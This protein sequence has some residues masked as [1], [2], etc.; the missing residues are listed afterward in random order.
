MSKG[1]GKKKKKR[2]AVIEKYLGGLFARTEEYAQQVS[3]YYSA[4]VEALLDLAATADK[5][6]DEVFRFSDHKRMSA[7]ATAKPSSASHRPMP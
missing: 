1:D 4:A 7:K 2:K 3:M 5:E 6:P